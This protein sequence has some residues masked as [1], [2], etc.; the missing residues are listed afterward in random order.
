V[1]S[2]SPT[3][4]SPPQQP[5]ES[6]AASSITCEWDWHWAAVGRPVFGPADASAQADGGKLDMALASCVCVRACVRACICA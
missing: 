3:A 4:P 2:A 5:R 6:R 1:P